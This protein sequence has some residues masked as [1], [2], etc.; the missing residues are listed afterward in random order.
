MPN[1]K[2]ATLWISLILIIIF[3]FQSFF[4]QTTNIFILNSSAIPE[5]WRFLTAIFLHAST[6]H[7]ISNLFAL[8]IFGLMLETIIGTK[9][10]LIVF[11]VSGIL[12]N[13][14]SFFFYPSSL[15]ASGAIMGIIG[16]LAIIRPL[17]AVWA[18]GMIIPMFI[19]AIIWIFIDAIGVFIP[20]NTGHIAHLSGIFFGVIFGIAFK[21]FHE[22]RKKRQV[23]SI[24]EHILRRWETIYMGGD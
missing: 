15:G 19:A 22:K 13:I 21:Q 5:I 2:Y 4:P 9:R 10:F 16:T 14:V 7:L 17:M 11:F 6:A 23:I 3:A 20:D 12:A 18:F 8:I 1:V 24:P